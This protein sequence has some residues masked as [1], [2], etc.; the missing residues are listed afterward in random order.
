[1][2]RR[3]LVVSPGF[4]GYHASIARAF[5]ELGYDV[6]TFAYDAAGSTGEKVWN[7]VRHELPG[8]L[9]STGQHH[10]GET[11]SRRALAALRHFHPERV[12]VVRGD[13]LSEEFWAEASAHGRPVIVWMYDEMRR[14]AFEPGMVAPYARMA[15]YSARDAAAL[16]AAGLETRHVSLGFDAGASSSPTSLGSGCVSFVGAPSPARQ[17]ALS[18]LI[19]AGIPVGAWGRGWSDHYFDRARTWRLSSRRVPAGRDLAGPV[20][21][22]VMRNSLATLNIHGDQDGFTMRTFESCGVGAVQLVDRSDVSDFYEPSQEVLVYQ[23]EEELLDIAR[24]VLS[25]PQEF[26]GMRERAHRRT[27]AEHTLGHR[28]RVLAGMW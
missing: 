2:T 1:V 12:L 18:S 23:G 14:T 20:A 24:R 16:T 3:L 25:K 5:E 21:H 4:H 19:R 27:M 22:A 10:S 28:A 11:A 26:A 9:G 13:V 6:A 8:V 7:K 17:N 15:T